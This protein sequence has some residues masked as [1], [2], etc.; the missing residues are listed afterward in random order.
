MRGLVL[1]VGRAMT[2]R[3]RFA[4]ALLSLRLA[5]FVAHA[6]PAADGTCADA[7]GGA[8]AGS[9][10]GTIAA[11]GVAIADAMARLPAP[12]PVMADDYASHWAPVWYQDTDS[13]R[14]WAD[15]ITGVDFDGDWQGDN[16]WDN[17]AKGRGDRS[18]KIY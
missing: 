3:T 13:S 16:N 7:N 9:I 10:G 2:R 18:A 14:P 17:L 4:V 15:Y 1:H 6:A 11:I 8:G 5:P 12:A